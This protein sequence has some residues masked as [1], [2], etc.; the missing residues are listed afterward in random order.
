MSTSHYTPICTNEKPLETVVLFL[1]LN[2]RRQSAECFVQ[3]P[4]TSP[5]KS[6]WLLR[7]HACKIRFGGLSH[8]RAKVL[9]WTEVIHLALLTFPVE[10]GVCW[11]YRW[12][13][14]FNTFH[15]HLASTSSSHSS[16]QTVI[17]R[18][19]Y[20]ILG[21]LLPTTHLFNKMIEAG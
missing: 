12:L 3:P 6:Q 16:F 14:E 21:P 17:A 20:L 7:Y 18:K 4:S 2:I 19:N 1:N 11:A 15:L 8:I 10:C 9:M 5:T 13:D